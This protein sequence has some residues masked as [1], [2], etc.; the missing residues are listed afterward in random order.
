MLCNV[1]LYHEEPFPAAINVRNKSY[2]LQG[3]SKPPILIMNDNAKA[4]PER[5]PGS[6]VSGGAF[7]SFPV[8]IVPS[9]CNGKEIQIIFNQKLGVE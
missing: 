7:W 2:S 5:L 1:I 6:Y 3:C 9:Q 4:I 8:V